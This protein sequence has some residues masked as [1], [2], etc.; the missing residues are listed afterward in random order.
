MKKLTNKIRVKL[1]LEF[2]L[3]QMEKQNNNHISIM[4][5]CIVAIVV[6]VFLTKII[7]KVFVR[8]MD[9]MCNGCVI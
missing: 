3:E 6:Y 4:K 7:E 9:I 5:T 1:K 2:K 8:Y